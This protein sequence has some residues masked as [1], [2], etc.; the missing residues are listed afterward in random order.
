MPN[1]AQKAWIEA[2]AVLALTR[3]G[4]LGI[5]PPGKLREMLRALRDY[6]S[7]GAVSRIAAIRHGDQIVIDD[8]FG[9]ITFAGLDDLTNRISGVLRSRGL[10]P[11]STLGIYCRNHRLPLA[12][13]FA[14]SRA[15]VSAVWLNTAFSP[16]Q[17]KEVAEREGVQLLVHDAEFEDAAK[18]IEL[19]HGRLVCG[20]GDSDAEDIEAAAAAEASVL[21]PVPAKPG[22]IVLLT[23]GTTGTPKGAPRPEPKSL[24]LPGALLERM[25][26]RSREATV[27]GP[28]LYHGTG[29]LLALVSMA[30]GSKLILRRRFDAAEFLDDIERHRAT[31]VCLV[32]V[33]LQRLLAQGDGEIARRDLASLR[34]MFCAGSQLPGQVATR[35]MDRFGEVVYNLYGSTE[36]AV[37][38]LA[39]PADLREAPTTV[40]K[41]TLGSTVRVL[42]DSGDQ[43]PTGEVGRVFVGTGMPF[44]GYT[45]GG[46]KDNIDGLLA[47]GDLGHFDRQGRLYIDGRDDDMIVSGGE[48]LFPGEVEEVLITH[49]AV[50]EVAVIGVDDE[51][52]G[53]RLRAFVVLA[54]GQTATEREVK[55]FVKANLAAFKVPRDVVILGELPRNP[56]GKV[57]KRQLAVD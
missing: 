30:L 10:G 9:E 35:A 44:E 50:D 33:M 54:D 42:D 39:T 57:L 32:P 15:G 25:P 38:T 11:G 1:A 27:I 47:T 51:E 55:D 12:T 31:T 43:L 26:M 17:A 36:V 3:A 37:A 5:E 34:V 16:R 45:G 24:N 40:G 20:A 52:F 49:P 6:G 8:E 2:R 21:P 29:L 46:G 18:T 7:F 28:P 56:T 4:F 53:Q 19:G 23:S 48:N 13:A 41:P 14:A 22:R